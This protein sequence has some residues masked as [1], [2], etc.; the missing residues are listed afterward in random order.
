MEKPRGAAFCFAAAALERRRCLR[1][2]YAS[3]SGPPELLPRSLQYCQGL[4]FTVNLHC[5]CCSRRLVCALHFHLPNTLPPSQAPCLLPLEIKVFYSHNNMQRGMSGFDV[6]VT[7]RLKGTTVT[8]DVLPVRRNQQLQQLVC[9]SSLKEADGLF[10]EG[11][12]QDKTGY[13]SP[14]TTDKV[15]P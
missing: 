7:D 6:P 4:S 11:N 3:S 10:D 2:P 15:C 13:L 8:M 1:F 9:L 12:L 5:P 14:S